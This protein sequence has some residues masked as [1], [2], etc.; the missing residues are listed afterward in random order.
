M[1]RPSR[2]R[3]VFFIG[4][5]HHLPVL[6]VRSRRLPVDR[7]LDRLAIDPGAG[8]GKV[9]LGPRIFP[10]EAEA[11]ARQRHGVLRNA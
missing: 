2:Y 4:Q 6:E 3:R 7:H 1:P 11:R 8:V 9:T 5:Q 10:T